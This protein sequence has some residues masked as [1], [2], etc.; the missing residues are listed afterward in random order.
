MLSRVRQVRRLSERM[1]VWRGAVR[2]LTTNPTP[3]GR[4]ELMDDGSLVLWV[5]GPPG[6]WIAKATRSMN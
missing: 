3:E 6:T 2:E 5:E 4:F 1:E